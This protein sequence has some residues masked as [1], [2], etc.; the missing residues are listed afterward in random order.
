MHGWVV[1]DPR[2]KEGDLLVSAHGPEMSADVV[3]YSPQ[4]SGAS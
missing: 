4:V 1:S 2:K 3:A